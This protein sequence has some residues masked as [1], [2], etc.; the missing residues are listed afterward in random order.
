MA[1]DTG[2][3][4]ELSL[5]SD[6]WHFADLSATYNA[7]KGSGGD[8]FANAWPQITTYVGA[9]SGTTRGSGI[10]YT[11]GNIPTHQ[12]LGIA[13]LY[14]S[15]TAGWRYRVIDYGS[16]WLG[17]R[18]AYV[19]SDGITAFMTADLN[20]H[21]IEWADV[22]GSWQSADMTSL[23]GAPTLSSPFGP[24]VYV[25]SDNYNSVIH[26]GLANPELAYHPGSSWLV[27]SLSSRSPNAVSGYVR[28][29]G[30]NAV[31]FNDYDSTLRKHVVREVSLTGS[32]WQ[33]KDLT[34]DAGGHEPVLSGAPMA[35]K[36]S[37]NYN[38]VVYEGSDGR[39][40]ELFK[41]ASA[42][43][44]QEGDISN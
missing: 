23:Y 27:G 25:R 5:L 24:E 22:G 15:P 36:R 42:T 41:S 17:R 12:S 31:V 38:A 11:C 8:V 2:D 26:G 14:L 1:Q 18:G 3:I 28:S 9:E 35:Y 29:D 33:L 20:H 43:H 7:P 30:V 19:R 16:F 4:C 13:I 10:V 39:V 32:G 21:I 37:D 40:Y 44:W 6:G 34:S